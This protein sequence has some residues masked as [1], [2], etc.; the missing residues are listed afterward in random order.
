[1]WGFTQKY[2]I[3]WSSWLFLMISPEVPIKNSFYELMR[4]FDLEFLQKLPEWV[5][6]RT[7]RGV[8]EE[9]AQPFQEVTPEELSEGTFGG[10]LQETLDEF[11][12]K[13][14]NNC[15]KEFHN[16]LLE[17]TQKKN[18]LKLENKKNFCMISTRK[19]WKIFRGNFCRG[20]TKRTSRRFIVGTSEGNLQEISVGFS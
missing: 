20:F 19:S 15:H 3:R 1:M 17:E 8:S 4:E 7:F 18:H 2:L 6:E 5:P 11:F 14:I 10:F 12:W 16:K 13:H 9:T